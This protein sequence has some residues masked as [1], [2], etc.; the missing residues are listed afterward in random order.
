MGSDLF[1]SASRGALTLYAPRKN[2]DG[3]STSE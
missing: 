3:F 1:E 2:E